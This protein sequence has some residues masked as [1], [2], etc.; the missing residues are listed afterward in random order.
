[1]FRKLVFINILTLLSASS[2][3]AQNSVYAQ[4]S[5]ESKGFYR[6]GIGGVNFEHSSYLT[7]PAYDGYLH[8]HEA[9]IT[10]NFAVGYGTDKLRALVFF[11]P[12]IVDGIRGASVVSVGVKGE[13]GVPLLKWLKLGGGVMYSHNHAKIS[14]DIKIYERAGLDTVWSPFLSVAFLPRAEGSTR[15]FADIRIGQARGGD[16]IQPQTGKPVA[17]TYVSVS[18]GVHLKFKD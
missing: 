7:D 12:T 17:D 13:I 4:D 3:Y 5:N 18:L 16:V 8:F 14:D 9:G 6:I 1:M 10:A 11:D 15:F 2:V